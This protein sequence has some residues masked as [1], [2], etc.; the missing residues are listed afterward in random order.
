MPL[1]T[2]LFIKTSLGYL[3]L[4]LLASWLLSMQMAG[5]IPPLLQGLFPVTV[6]LFV[7]GWVT[8]LIFGVVHW[9]FP[10][11]SRQ[12]TRGNP[13]LTWITYVSLNLGL[14]LRTAGEPLHAARPTALSG[15]LL[16]V[17]AL[18]LWLAGAAFV[19]NTWRRVK[20]R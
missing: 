9:M 10:L 20:E 2:R 1:L 11:Y 8:Q 12:K 16:A 17:S 14:A 5:F 7:L 4:A 13:S 19:A 15:W 18:L 3:L 6:H